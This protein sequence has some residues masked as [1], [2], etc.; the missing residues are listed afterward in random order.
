M[1][2]IA[3]VTASGSGIGAAVAVALA[4]ENWTV[5]L[6]GRRLE[7]LEGAAATAG[8]GAMAIACDVTDPASV[9]SLFA[10]IDDRYGRLDLLFNNAGVSAPAI[11]LEEL[12]V[13]EWR[14]VVDTNLTGAFLCTQEAFRLMKRQVPQGGRIINN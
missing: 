8:N 9:R 11:L 10:E 3:L 4:H 2:R 5:V 7:L 14:S 1:T 13:D 12:G 6:A